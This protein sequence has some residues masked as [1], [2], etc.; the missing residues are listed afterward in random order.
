MVSTGDDNMWRVGS[1]IPRSLK[2]MLFQTSRNVTCTSWSGFTNFWSK[3][4]V[5]I[6]KGELWISVYFFDLTIWVGT[7]CYF[8][9]IYIYS[10]IR[11]IHILFSGSSDHFH[12]LRVHS[13]WRS[14]YLSAGTVFIAVAIYY[15]SM[16][17]TYWIPDIG[18]CSDIKELHK[19][20]QIEHSILLQEAIFSTCF[21]KLSVQ[22]VAPNNRNCN[23]D[24]RDSEKKNIA[25]HFI[26]KCFWPLKLELFQRL[27]VTWSPASIC[28]A[29]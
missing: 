10:D 6:R 27:L 1:G 19:H 8:F 9:C 15:I 20:L 24:L 25:I 3:F 28:F 21:H 22:C 11:Y 18:P 16:C 14:R 4:L 17:I 23:M 26:R 13:P 29:I 5:L 12:N 7:S 2:A